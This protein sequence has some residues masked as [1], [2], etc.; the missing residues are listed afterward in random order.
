MKEKFLFI[1][2]LIITGCG[3]TKKDLSFNTSFENGNEKINFEVLSN[4]QVL[5]LNKINKTRFILKNIDKSKVSISGK[6][7]RT[8]ENNKLFENEIHLDMS[9]KEEDL[10]DGRL[11]VFLTYKM[12]E[13][14]RFFKL[15]IPVE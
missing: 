12:Q 1:L 15:Q 5:K 9:P 13:K 2:I 3:T 4:K 8:S 11:N 14:L 6:S 10:V 7:I